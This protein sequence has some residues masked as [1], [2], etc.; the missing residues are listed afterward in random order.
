M[1]DAFLLLCEFKNFENPILL[2]L[3]LSSKN[4]S[5]FFFALRYIIYYIYIKI[6]YFLKKLAML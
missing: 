1:R 5:V 4:I 2:S 3:I 6:I